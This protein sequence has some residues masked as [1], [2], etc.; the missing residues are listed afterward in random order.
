MFS[1]VCHIQFY[2]RS[3]SGESMRL[4]VHLE[5]GIHLHAVV[6]HLHGTILFALIVAQRLVEQVVGI[7]I[8]CEAG[9]LAPSVA[10]IQVEIVHTVVVA[11]ELTAGAHLVDE[12]RGEVVREADAHTRLLIEERG[13]GGVLR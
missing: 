11:V 13:I 9:L 5:T 3:G 4:E 2:Q 6:F 8:Y 1:E 7:G 10:G 12:G